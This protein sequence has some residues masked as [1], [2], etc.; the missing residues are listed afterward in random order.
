MQPSALVFLLHLLG[1]D[2]LGLALVVG[3]VLPGHAD[4]LGEHAVV[5]LDLGGDVLT[6]D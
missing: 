2:V 5:G 4:D 1:F 3:N 6:L